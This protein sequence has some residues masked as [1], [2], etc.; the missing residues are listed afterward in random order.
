MDGVR[1]LDD[2]DRWKTDHTRKCGRPDPK[3]SHTRESAARASLITWRCN[4]CSATLTV[5]VRDTD[6]LAFVQIL[7][8][9]AH[10]SS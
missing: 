2:F 8:R 5:R 7:S 6:L 4:R 9:P 1:T 3:V 10:V